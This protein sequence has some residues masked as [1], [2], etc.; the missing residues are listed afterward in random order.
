MMIVALF[1]SQILLVDV[2]HATYSDCSASHL[3]SRIPGNGNAVFIQ[4]L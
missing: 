1:I 3:F 2:I 4:R